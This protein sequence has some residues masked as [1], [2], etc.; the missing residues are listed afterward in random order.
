VTQRTKRSDY[1]DHCRASVLVLGCGNLLLGDDGFGPTVIK[2]YLAERKPTRGLLLMDAHTSVKNVLFDILLS[3][4]R[5]K[6]LIIVDAVDQDKAPG[7]VFELDIN[8]IPEKNRDNFS[9]HQ[10]AGSDLLKELEAV[11][12]RVRVLACQVKCIPVEVASGLSPEIEGAIAKACD[13]I[14]EWSKE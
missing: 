4:I 11:G 8:S 9:L 14:D 7:T 10:M 5:P 12:V 13:V 2:R 6:S 3:D 1:P